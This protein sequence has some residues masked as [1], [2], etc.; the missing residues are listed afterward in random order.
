MKSVPAIV[1]G[2][3]V[4]TIVAIGSAGCQSPS[5]VTRTETVVEVMTSGETRTAETSAVDD[6]VLERLSEE[7]Q[8]DTL[9]VTGYAPVVNRYPDDLRRNTGLA[10]AGALAQAYAA[11]AQQVGAVTVTETTTVNDMATSQIIQIRLQETIRGAYIES[12]RMNEA[13]GQYEVTLGLPKL[14]LMRVIRESRR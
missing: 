2:S 8:F 5:P 7:W 4:A 13:D 12:E 6:V 14:A 9:R 1:I 11:L 10:R 3:L